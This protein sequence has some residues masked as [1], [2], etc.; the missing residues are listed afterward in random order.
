VVWKHD[1]RIEV[2]YLVVQLRENHSGMETCEQLSGSAWVAV[3]RENHS[4]M[5][6]SFRRATVLL[7]LGCVRTIVVWKPLY[8][9]RFLALLSSLRENHSGMETFFSQ[10]PMEI[11]KVA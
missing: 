3:L 10:V 5:E 7:S 6:T 8:P 11:T 9:W 2:L 4:G 1:V